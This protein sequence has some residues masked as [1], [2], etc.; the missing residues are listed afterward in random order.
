MAENFWGHNMDAKELTELFNGFVLRNAKNACSITAVRSVSQLADL[1]NNMN[2]VPYAGAQQLSKMI[3]EYK[4]QLT[5]IVPSVRSDS[6]EKER[7]ALN[8][9]IKICN[10]QNI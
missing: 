2:K 6:Y 5:A 1:K 3:L 8:E 10:E 9:L 4:N 7:D